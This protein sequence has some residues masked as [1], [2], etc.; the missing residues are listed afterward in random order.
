MVNL[1]RLMGSNRRPFF[2]SEGKKDSLLIDSSLKVVPI[3]LGTVE[4]DH[5]V[6]RHIAIS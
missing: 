2:A 1:Q 5:R 6:K 3:S 4:R